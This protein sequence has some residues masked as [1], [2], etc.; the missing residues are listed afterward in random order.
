MNRNDVD[1]YGQ[2]TLLQRLRRFAYRQWQKWKPRSGFFFV[3]TVKSPRERRKD[4]YL[5]W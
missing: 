3:N 4:A 2:A 5:K 1:T